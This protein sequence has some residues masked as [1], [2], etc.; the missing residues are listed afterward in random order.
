MVGHARAG[1]Q[2]AERRQGHRRHGGNNSVAIPH[3]LQ[4]NILIKTT[5]IAASLYARMM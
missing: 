5:N 2:Q 1:G 3:C 4:K